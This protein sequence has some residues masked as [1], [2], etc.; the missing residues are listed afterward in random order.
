MRKKAQ[1]HEGVDELRK[2]CGE[3]IEEQT[4]ALLLVNL[5]I[6]VAISTQT[7][8]YACLDAL[9]ATAPA[10]NARIPIFNG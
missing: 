3:N 4:V 1:I 10:F 5:I 9:F 6:I 7:P 2:L 8:V